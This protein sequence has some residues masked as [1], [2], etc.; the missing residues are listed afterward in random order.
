MKFL[1]TFTFVSPRREENFLGGIRQ[2]CYTTFYP[3]MLFPQKGF[4]Q[5]DFEDITILYGGNGSGKSTALNIIVDT[6]GASRDTIYNRSNFFADYVSMCDVDYHSFNYKTQC[7]ITSDGVFDNMIDIRNINEQIDVNR[8]DMY[9]EYSKLRHSDFKLQSIDQVDELRRI[10]SARRNTK[11]EF[12]RQN[13]S[14]N[15][16]EYS[17]GESAFQY[18]VNKIDENGIYILDEPENSLSPEKQIELIK[19]IENAARYFNCQFVIATHS[20]FILAMRGAKIYDLDENPVDIK[21][22]TEL[23]N[24]RTYYDFFKGRE[25]EFE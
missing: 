6:I 4:R 25:K 17:N 9:A 8:A 18:F 1:D 11:S 10:N 13:L 3:F 22:W 2:T 19:Y 23:K 12:V 16:R 20:P 7:I 24:V 15:V 5:I 14:D 21:N